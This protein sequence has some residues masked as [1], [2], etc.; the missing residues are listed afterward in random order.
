MKDAELFFISIPWALKILKQTDFVKL[1]KFRNNFFSRILEFLVSEKF[2]NNMKT[3][4]VFKSF[5]FYFKTIVNKVTFSK[6]SDFLVQSEKNSKF[7]NYHISKM[8]SSD[9]FFQSDNFKPKIVFWEN[10]LLN[11]LVGHFFVLIIYPN[12]LINWFYC[13][14]LSKFILG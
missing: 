4:H 13:N 5:I 14:S 10:V 8:L 9:G 3:I 2:A 11:L 12:D 1:V 7:S 6:I